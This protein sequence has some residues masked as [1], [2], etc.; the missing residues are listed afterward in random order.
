LFGFI[1]LTGGG[2]NDLLTGDGNNNTIS[3]GAGND[4]IEGLGG[5]DTLNGDGNSTAGDTVSYAHS[6]SLVT[7]D[8]TLATGQSGGDASGDVLTGF[9]NVLGSDYDDFLVGDDGA[10]VLT[11]GAGADY[12]G[13]GKG[14]DTLNGGLHDDLISGGAGAD[15]MDGGAGVDTLYYALSSANVTVTLGAEGVQTT[16]SGA[17]NSDAIGDKIKNFEN[18]IGSDFNDTITGNGGANVLN[19][20]AGADKMTGGAGADE[21]VFGSP[22]QGGDTITDFQTGI[23]TISIDSNQ[24]AGGLIGY[25]FGTP[26][27]DSLLISDDGAVSPNNST[28]YFLYD[29]ATS[30]LWWDDDGTDPNAAQLIATFTNGVDLHAS[31]ILLK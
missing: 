9:E 13:G 30:K 18:V 26:L 6:N 28:G 25:G 21:F 4:T 3:G 11:G 1:H 24:F 12:L 8:L 2:G 20:G 17:T 15:I 27:P 19:G 5:A 29:T 10:N 14:A 23:D 16:A 22:A 31:D 7:V